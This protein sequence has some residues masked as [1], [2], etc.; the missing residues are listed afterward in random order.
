M[1]HLAKRGRVCYTGRM[2]KRFLW[3]C[4][5]CALT[6]A[7]CACALAEETPLESLLYNAGASEIYVAPWGD[8]NDAGT[9]EEPLQTLGEALLR[10]RGGVS[11]ATIW[12]RGGRYE[13]SSALLASWDLPAQLSVRAYGDEE[14]VVT[15]SARVDGWRETELCGQ[16]VWA[17]QTSYGAINALYGD[18][19]ARQSARWP[20]MGSLWVAGTLEEDAENTESNAFA[21]SGAFYVWPESLPFD[22]TGC[23]VRLVHW[24]KDEC[25]TVRAYSAETGRVTLNR[26]TTM[27]VQAG[28]FFWLENVWQAPMTAGEWAFD[29]A[30]RTLYYCPREGETM[31]NTPLYAGVLTRLLAF[32]GV[33]GLTLEGITSFVCGPASFYAARSAEQVNVDVAYCHRDVKVIGVS[34]FLRDDLENLLT[35]C[36]VR[37][38][39]NQILLHISNTDKALVNFCKEQN[40]QVEAYSPIAHGE[41]LKNPAIAA[42]A[43]KYGVTAAQLCIRYVIQLGAVAL[44][45]TADPVHMKDNAAVDFVISDEDM[46]ALVNMDRI[47]SYGEFNIFPVFSGKPLA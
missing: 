7:L 36:R 47:Q 6:A 5:L 2:M 38:M 29:E 8:D 44:P 33:S 41:A 13:L 40:I 22:P 42:M 21:R 23:R 26:P 32:E 16:T 12:L 25:T 3:I 34:N 17:A 28:D 4:A 10:V 19:G 20:K 35:D 14:P 39:V 30:T 27:T 15:G 45:K 37:P 11:G 1:R 18:D 9:L 31:E 46:D 43:Q 24:W